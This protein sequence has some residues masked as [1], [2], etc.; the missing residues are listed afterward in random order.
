MG[1]VNQQRQFKLG[2]RKVMHRPLKTKKRH[3]ASILFWCRAKPLFCVRI[4]CWWELSLAAEAKEH[5]QIPV[6]AS[7][8][9]ARSSGYL[10]GKVIQCKYV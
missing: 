6:S 2:K 10:Y 5:V 1:S 9:G 3:F 7:L 4:C 8:S